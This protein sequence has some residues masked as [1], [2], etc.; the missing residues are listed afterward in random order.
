MSR[1]VHDRVI[2]VM[3]QRLIRENDEIHLNETFSW[4]GMDSIDEIDVLMAIEHEF[5]HD[6]PDDVIQRICT[7][8]DV[9]K[10]FEGIN[11]TAAV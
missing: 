7:P 10:Y 1:S 6:I 3:A 8:G 2:K 9:I 4:H 11:E 5:N